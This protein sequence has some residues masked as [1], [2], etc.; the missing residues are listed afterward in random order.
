M[1]GVNWA[2]SDGFETLTSMHFPDQKLKGNLGFLS[3]DPTPNL[4]PNR[5]LRFGSNPTGSFLSE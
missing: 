5:A 4:S 1:I 2:E 3:K